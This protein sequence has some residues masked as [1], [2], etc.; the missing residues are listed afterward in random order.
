[1]TVFSAL[2]LGLVASNYTGPGHNPALGSLPAGS[3]LQGPTMPFLDPVMYRGST[4]GCG[5]L[6]D[7]TVLVFC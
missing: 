6:R 5:T 1:M 7:G 2:V 4:F 3:I